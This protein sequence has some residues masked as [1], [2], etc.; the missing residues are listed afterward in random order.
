MS[1]PIEGQL[2]PDFTLPA[3]G[4][5]QSITL[6]ELRGKRVVLFFYPK[7]DT[8]GC[9]VEACAFR[10]LS[11]AFAAAGVVVLGLSKDALGAHEKFTGKFDLNFPLLADTETVV[12]GDELMVSVKVFQPNSEA[13]KIG[14]ITL[15]VPY[16]SKVTKVEPP[17][18]NNA[19][20]NS[21][22]IAAAG[23]VFNVK[24]DQSTSHPHE[25]S[26]AS[27]AA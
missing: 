20:Y 9:T 27:M 3:S 5:T 24:V 25:N 11:T 21:R 15:S 17:K 1:R 12:P 13:I 6:S 23:A 7:D 16:K 22:E 26:Q 2:A 4:T 19:A 14:E 8:P 18:Q 10:D